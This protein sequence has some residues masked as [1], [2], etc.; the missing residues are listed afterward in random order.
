MRKFALRTKFALT[1]ALS[2]RMGEGKSARLLK[3]YRAASRKQRPFVPPS[4]IRW[5]RA[6]ARVLAAIITSALFSSTSHAGAAQFVLVSKGKPKAE[7]VVQTN[8]AA[9]PPT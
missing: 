6:G 4:P 2:H 7:I 8:P 3:S 9:E 5:E 1:P